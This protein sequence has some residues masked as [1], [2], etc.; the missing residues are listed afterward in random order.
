MVGSV[1]MRAFTWDHVGWLPS[2]FLFV[3]DLFYALRI[4]I[5]IPETNIAPKN[6][7]LEYYFPI[8][9][10]YFQGLC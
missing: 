8:G 9:K 10:A 5:T 4:Y 6:G 1:L 2:V 3:P 7:W